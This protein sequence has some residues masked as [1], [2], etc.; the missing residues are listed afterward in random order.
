MSVNY[1]HCYDLLQLNP[2]ATW[3]ELRKNYKHLVQRCHPDR[4]EQD[5]VAR[6]EAEV[7]LR[8]LNNAYQVLSGYYKSH[9][10]LPLGKAAAHSDWQFQ[11]TSGLESREEEYRAAQKWPVLNAV[12][13]KWVVLGVPL[14]LIV[15]VF[16][17]LL[18]QFSKGEADGNEEEQHIPSSPLQPASVAAK[19]DSTFRYGDSSKQVLAVQGSPTRISG[20]SWFYGKSRVDF[21]Q[22]Y[23]VGWYIE[24][25]PLQASGTSPGKEQKQID[26][27]MSMEQ[28]LAIQGVP[29]MKSRRRWDYGASFIEFRNGKVVGWYS[30]VLR[31][32]AVDEKSRSRK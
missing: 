17:F 16:A 22:G 8:E 29:V 18:S 1:R 5:P 15:L 4:F 28:V 14:G 12:V 6:E 32:L 2:D 3:E 27:G 19:A 11:N 9:R 10:R 7:Q 13:S 24:G 30:S 25:T 21:E 23:V 31:P 20:D 26:M